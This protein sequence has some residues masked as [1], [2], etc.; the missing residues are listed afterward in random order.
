MPI[1]VLDQSAFV[2]ALARVDG[3]SSA[4]MIAALRP[5]G[6]TRDLQCYVKAFAP[7]SRGV[8]N[9]VT[10]WI[11]AGTRRLTQP[12][13]AW[14]VFLPWD[15]LT[16][17]WPERD[18]GTP[19][20]D[21]YPAFA[22]LRLNSTV[23]KARIDIDSASDID[24]LRCWLKLPDKIAF[25]EW[26]ANADSN[27]SNLIRLSASRFAGI[28][29]GEI[30]GGQHWRADQLPADTGNASKLWQLMTRHSMDGELAGRIIK[31][32]EYH[33]PTLHGSLP[34]LY[35][36]WLQVLQDIEISALVHWLNHRADKKWMRGRLFPPTRLSRQ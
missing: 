26:T 8:I 15:C 5:P 7:G 18:W 6:C 31:S 19:D 33:P 35:E 17:V 9:E 36:F 23:P 29:H 2:S 27:T 12:R 10:G 32:A 24:E 11:L 3:Y 28:D 20:P 21:G 1:P 22:T 25:D 14:L 30:F 34:A 13:M 16:S 4:L